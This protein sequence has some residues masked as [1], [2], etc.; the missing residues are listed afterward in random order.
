MRTYIGVRKCQIARN[1]D[2]SHIH[3]ENNNYVNKARKGNRIV[4]NGSN[5]LKLKMKGKIQQESEEI[6]KE[7]K[8][9][10]KQFSFTRKP[11]NTEEAIEK[12]LM[13]KDFKI[14]IAQITDN[15][16]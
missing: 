1:N 11:E 8:E 3:N 13:R 15:K 14:I 10:H 2:S 4:N 9:L 16:I 12:E 6:V 5:M 7:Y